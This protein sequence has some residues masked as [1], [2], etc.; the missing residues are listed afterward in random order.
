MNIGEL[1]ASVQEYCKANPEGN[2]SDYLQTLALYSDID[3]MD[4]ADYV[5]VATVHAVKGLEF[6]TVFVAGMEDK[7]FPVSRAS[8]SADDTEEERRLLYV[9]MTRAEKRLYLTR[10]ASRFMYGQRS[11]TLASP[12]LAEIEGINYKKKE[13]PRFNDD[14]GFSFGGGWGKG[15][16]FGSGGYGGKSGFGRYKADESGYEP[17]YFPDETPGKSANKDKAAGDFKATFKIGTPP[18]L[19]RASDLAKNN[20]EFKAG[21]CVEHPKFGRGIIQS[22]S[23]DNIAEIAFGAAGRKTLSLSFAPLIKIVS[24]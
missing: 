4:E 6:N 19:V 9:A 16:G 11:P 20:A 17:D 8:G 21:D 12:F 24:D 23:G 14:G 5:T 13:R 1:G 2:L 7:I 3:E 18:N 15:G 10:A 22:V